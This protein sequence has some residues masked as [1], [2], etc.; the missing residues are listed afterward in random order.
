MFISCKVWKNK[1]ISSFPVI[2]CN[3]I[4]CINFCIYPV[5]VAVFIFGSFNN[6][7]SAFLYTITYLTLVLSFILPEYPF[8]LNRFDANVVF[9]LGVIKMFFFYLSLFIMSLR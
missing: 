3:T 5:V 8:G 7:Q 4:Q 1:F 9:G 6:I 2:I